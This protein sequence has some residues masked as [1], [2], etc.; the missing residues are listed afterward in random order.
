MRYKN[1][2]VEEQDY[3][4]E[5][6]TKRSLIKKGLF[7]AIAIPTSLVL[8]I[9]LMSL[10]DVEEINAKD[11]DAK[12]YQIT[13]INYNDGSKISNPSNANKKMP[14]KYNEMPKCMKEAIV[15]I[16]DERY[17]EHPGVDFKGL[18]RSAVK[19]LLGKNQ[20]GSTITMQ[21]SKM[22]MTSSEVSIPRKIKDIWYAFQMDKT[23]GKDK[24]LELYLNN[25][26]VGRGLQ[27]VKAGA[28]G[29]FNKNLNQL[30]V[31]EA[32]MLAGATKNPSKF[33]AYITEP[34]NCTETKEQLDHKLL[35]FT[36]TPND[37]FEEPTEAQIDF[38]DKLKEWELLPDADTYQQLKNGTMVVRKATLNHDA[39]ERQETVIDKMYEV[40]YLNQS[41]WKKYK[42]AP[43]EI[44]L[45]DYEVKVSSSIEDYVEEEAIR[46]LIAAG[47]TE[48]EALN[49]YFNGGLTVT[50]SVDKVMQNSLED[51][52]SNPGNFPRHLVGEDGIVQPQSASVIL[53]NNTSQIKAMVGGRNIVGRKVLNRATSPVQPGS[54]IKP[55]AVYTPAIESKRLNEAS[56]FDDSE[57]GYRFEKNQGWNPN[58]TTGGHSVFNLKTAL[59]KSSNTIAVKV[60]ETLGDTY[61][62]CVDIMIDQLKDFGIS[63]II[64]SKEGENDREFASLTLGG[65]ARGISP[66]DMA[67]AYASLANKGEYTEP[68]IITKIEAYD[69]TVL[70]NHQK[71]SHRVVS[72]DVAYIMTDM[73][74]SVTV[75]GTGKS[76]KFSSMPVAGKT[77]TT[78]DDLE[79]WFVG[80]TPYYTC[81]TYIADDAGRVDKNGNRIERRGVGGGSKSSA[82]LWAKIMAEAHKGLTVKPFPKPGN[83]KLVENLYYLTGTSAGVD[84]HHSFDEKYLTEV[85]L[86]KLE[87]ENKGKLEEMKRQPIIEPEPD[88]TQLVPYDGG[89]SNSVF[90]IPYES[91]VGGA[92]DGQD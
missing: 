16:E 86:D 27:G 6:I 12:T 18:V 82:K 50:T 40:G 25:F 54:S 37:S 64:D 13:T 53:D 17:Y 71:N 21:T 69:G 73:L 58:T 20:G 38:A 57:G 72:E 75:N 7:T 8:G 15:A 24:V 35:F 10:K 49:M 39:K 42:E 29:Y 91:S 47:Y 52:Y 33:S 62:E 4:P 79:A 11:L 66:L 51:I 23:L 19:T 88:L 2:D 1:I 60:A 63:S 85:E 76:A 46:T 77:G 14:V 81:A 45:P 80:Y 9:T 55:L 43:I 36:N 31:P 48:D 34:L 61:D 41:E 56:Q 89:Q 90:G 22:L 70:Y 68:K 26:P 87:S 3:D 44:Q 83:V 65:M 5:Q 67:A 28:K 92:L 84:T 59:T 32:A 30:T 78:N 74:H